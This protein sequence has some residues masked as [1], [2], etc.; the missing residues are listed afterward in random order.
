[1]PSLPRLAA[2][3]TTAA[4]LV[5][6]LALAQDGPSPEERAVNARQSHMRLYQHNLGTLGGMAQ[7]SVEF[8]AVSAQAAADNLNHLV[9]LS[10]Q[11]YW[12]P[13]T[14][15]E[16]IEGTRA[17]PAIWENM[18][19]FEAKHAALQEAVAALQEAAG[20]DQASLGAAMGGVGQA[21]GSCH[22]NYRTD[23]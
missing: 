19:D 21:C 18:E 14:S 7:G 10:H 22:E 13:G 4:L 9:Q 2:L 17:S 3:T 1:M 8:D 11:G 23:Q 6:S 5:G 16:E 20:T 15:S 12:L